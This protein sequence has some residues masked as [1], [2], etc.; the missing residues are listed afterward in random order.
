M[1]WQMAAAAPRAAQAHFPPAAYQKAVREQRLALELSAGKRERDFYLKQVD[2]AKGLA[3]MNEKQAR[4]AAAAAAAAAEGGGEGEQAAPAPQRKPKVNR[5]FHQRPVRE[6]A[7]APR[8]SNS[9]LA[10]IFG[11]GGGEE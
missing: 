7:K 5:T 10:S 2:T 3:A 11:Q 4:K 1:R 9:T 8:I 6:K